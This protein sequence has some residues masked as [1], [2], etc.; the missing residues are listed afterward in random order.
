MAIT[1]TNA[2]KQ[3]NKLSAAKQKRYLRSAN[4]ARN[5]KLSN[6]ARHAAGMKAAGRSG[7]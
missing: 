6:P 3:F 1:A 2:R 5:R 7:G 4:S